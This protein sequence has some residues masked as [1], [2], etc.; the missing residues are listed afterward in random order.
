MYLDHFV[1]QIF[2]KQLE[3]CWKEPRLYTVKMVVEKLDDG[4]QAIFNGSE[5]KGEMKKEVEGF[6]KEQMNLSIRYNMKQ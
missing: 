2:T 1:P 4:R 6:F 3:G 5:L